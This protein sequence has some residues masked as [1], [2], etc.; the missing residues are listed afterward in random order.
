[1]RFLLLFL[2]ASSAF[3]QIGPDYQRPA[4]AT[5]PRY[6][7]A[8]TWREARPADRLPKGEWWRIFRDS[9]LN[10]LMAEATA[11][12]QQ[13]KGAIARFDQAR[14]TTQIAGQRL[15][16]TVNLIKALGGGWTAE[17]PST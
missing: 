9:R 11:N 7:N 1:M 5:S 6:K 3:A 14:A 2:V 16:A 13:L 15:I 10:D 8:V 4:T 17:A 12:N